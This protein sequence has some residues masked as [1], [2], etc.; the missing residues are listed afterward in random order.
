[1]SGRKPGLLP[2]RSIA[3]CLVLAA[4]LVRT[5]SGEADE[6]LHRLLSN[7]S[8]L[9]VR[10]KTAGE[11][12]ISYVEI[13]PRRHRL[14]VV[15]AADQ[16]NGAS[17][18]DFLNREAAAVAFT[19]GYLRTFA[20]PAPTGYLLVDGVELNPIVRDDPVVNAILCLGRGVS[21]STVVRVI[22]ARTFRRKAPHEDCIQAGPLL[23]EE[24]VAGYDLG[25]RDRLNRLSGEFE[26][27]FLALNA[28]RSIILGVSSRTTL[29]QLRQILMA[30]PEAGGFGAQ[31]A[32]ILTGA[33]TAGMEVRGGLGYSFGTTSTP[34]ANAILV[35]SSTRL[36]RQ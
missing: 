13:D 26:R 7:G 18:R 21:A 24:G 9:V 17:L 19:G 10:L 33:T 30:P 8:E 14:D 5:S 1:M 20:P 2:R 35:D 12:V 32:L 15:L 36:G 23:I 11:T 16:Q 4:S 6:Q 34:L 25:R 27:A 22:P 29:H 28:K 31:S 3:I